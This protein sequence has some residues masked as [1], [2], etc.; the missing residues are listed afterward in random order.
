M[1][2]PL[3][4]QV[5]LSCKKAEYFCG[6]H[7]KC[8]PVSKIDHLHI[9]DIRHRWWPSNLVR[10]ISLNRAT[11]I[12]CSSNWKLTVGPKSSPVPF[13]GFFSGKGRIR[14]DGALVLKKWIV[15]CDQ[16]KPCTSLFYISSTGT[17]FRLS[18]LACSSLKTIMYLT[19]WK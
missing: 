7:Q 11:K 5:L 2:I 10:T 17:E 4:L 1:T 9:D 19:G 16:K 18:C 15:I 3:A 12:L 6:L 8:F 13:L 14:P